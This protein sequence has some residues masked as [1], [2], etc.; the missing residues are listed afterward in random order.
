MLGPAVLGWRAGGLCVQQGGRSTA[1]STA[2]AA[3]QG[4][5]QQLSWGRWCGQGFC[6]QCFCWQWW[7]PGGGRH[8][9]VERE[10]QRVLTNGF[11][12]CRLLM[13]KSSALLS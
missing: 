5:E 8:P 1:G 4:A 11:G 6:W 13:W 9:V 7:H 12:S 10:I 3:G 2:T